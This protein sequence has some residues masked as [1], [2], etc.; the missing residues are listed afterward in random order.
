MHD[1]VVKNKKMKKLLIVLILLPF[2]A[3]CNHEKLKTV[4]V[5]FQGVEVN[6]TEGTH[7]YYLKQI[8]GDSLFVNVYWIP[9]YGK[10]SPGRYI[11]FTKGNNVKS[12]E[13][14]TGGKFSEKISV[15]QG[16]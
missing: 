9:D 10:Y 4:A 5:N 8:G 6:L 2:F 14:E 12:L 13:W 11:Y 16:K 1:I 7:N 3:S 15:Q